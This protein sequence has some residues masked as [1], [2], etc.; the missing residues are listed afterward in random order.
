M[1]LAPAETSSYHP[2]SEV[3][4]PFLFKKEQR[5]IQDFQR[6]LLMGLCVC[7]CCSSWRYR[8]YHHAPHRCF[9]RGLI[10][11]WC[12]K[13]YSSFPLCVLCVGKPP[14]CMIFS[15]NVYLVEGEVGLQVFF[16]VKH[17]GC[18]LVSSKM[19][20]GSL[21][22]S[23]NFLFPFTLYC[24]FFKKTTVPFCRMKT[25]KGIVWWGISLWTLTYLTKVRS[26]WEVVSCEACSV[27]LALNAELTVKMFLH[28]QASSFS[29][30]PNLSLPLSAYPV[31]L[32]IFIF[33]MLGE[34]K[35]F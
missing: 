35:I 31:P 3:L 16:C 26:S 8:K 22:S 9:S 32:F 23:K 30:K 7:L 28:L 14:L 10:Y 25:S 19:R 11:G 12:V 5:K 6:P 17:K 27:C 33:W 2:R 29:A 4:T 15:E 18:L 21:L 24:E 34:V 1:V 13:P 20:R